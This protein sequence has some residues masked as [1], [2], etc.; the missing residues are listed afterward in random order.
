MPHSLGLYSL[1]L[2]NLTSRPHLAGLPEDLESAEVVA[3]R[4]KNDGL[5][6]IKP[7]YNVLLSYSDDNNLNRV[8]LTSD[9]GSFIIQTNGTEKVYDLTQPKTVNPFLAYTPNGTV[10]STKL[11]YSNYGTLED[12]QKLASVVGNASLQGSIIIMR[13]GSFF[14][15]DKI[16]HAQYFGA[17]GAI[18]YNDPADYAPFGTTA[19]QVYD[20]TWYMPPSGAQRGSVLILDDYMYRLKEENVKYL[21][22][23][24]AQPI[25][26]AE[27]QVI[28]QYLEGNEVPVEWRGALPNV[29][30]RYGGELHNGSTIEVKTYNRLQR[31]D[32]YDVIGIM[33]GDIELDRY[34][35]MG[36]HRDAW[37]LGAIDPTSGTATMLEITR[38]LGEMYK[39]GFR[40][41]RSLM[42]CSWEA[43]EYGLIG[44]MEY[45]QVPSAYDAPGQTVYDKWMRVNRNNMTD[46]PKL[47]YGLGSGSDFF[48]FD[49]LVG[50]SNMDARYTY[51]SAEQRNIASHPLYHT[52][53]EV[54][55]MMKKFVDP[56]FTAH[57]TMGQFIGVLVLLLSETP[58]LQFNVT[59]YT[60]ALMQAMNNLKPNDP[61]ILDPLR[62][63]INDFGKTA[64]DFVAR[65]KLMDRENP[66]EI[67]FYNDQLL[68]LERSFLNPLRQGG[69]HTDFKHIVFAPAKDNQY[70]A[71]GFPT[72]SDAIFNN[73]QIEIEYQVAIAT[74][75]VRGALSILKDFNNFF[76]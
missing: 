65:S 64:E 55:S 66:Y 46:E 5:L 34:I 35:V 76:S 23:I 75:F 56:D 28:L 36:N 2:L 33:K 16:M 57:R 8:T 26:Y 19:D 43:E 74:Y 67:R 63:A 62:N 18:L 12:L 11:F 17:I 41:R 24:P 47:T 52:S 58:V 22:K 9:D 25:G 70:A 59:R 10:N 49:Q 40:P 21:P 53:Y 68:Q 37:S 32:T 30:Y 69:D 20:Q 14:R 48:S 29:T 45:V 54:F 42:F 39:N 71:S 27:A 38:V 31:K 4:W 15:G 6:V 7:K 72:I 61:T 1:Q 60:M 3:E 73:N 50:S 44:S 51:N 13:Y